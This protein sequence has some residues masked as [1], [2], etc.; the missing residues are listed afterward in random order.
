MGSGRGKKYEYIPDYTAQ[1]AYAEQ[2]RKEWSRYT[3]KYLPIAQNLI[4]EI[5]DHPEELDA[6]V[7]TSNQRQDQAATGA[8]DTLGMY[9]TQLSPIQREAMLTKLNASKALG[10]VT[11]R[12]EQRRSINDRNEALRAAL[13]GEGMGIRGL[14]TSALGAAAQAEQE[15]NASGYQ[16]AASKTAR[17][18]AKAQGTLGLIGQGVGAGL[19]AAALF[20]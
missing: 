15:R 19:T 4:G 7:N 13:V 17:S 1:N 14:S 12:T 18:Q 20:S 3:D 10:A 9:G 2:A 11:A 6:A 16:I 5:G 8:F